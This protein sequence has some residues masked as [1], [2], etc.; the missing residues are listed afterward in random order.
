MFGRAKSR[1]DSLTAADFLPHGTKPGLA[2]GVPAGFTFFPV[3]D[4]EIEG[5]D[6]FAAEDH[7]A[8]L[9]RG[10]V[11]PIAGVE[12]TGIDY[13]RPIST[14]VV[15]DAR[16]ARAT[17]AGQTVLSIANQDLALLHAA[18]ARSQTDRQPNERSH[19]IA[20]V[21]SRL[22]A[23]E[24]EKTVAD[25]IPSFDPLSNV[26]YTETIIGGK[27]TVKAFAGGASR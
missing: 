11:K 26:R 6:S 13:S 10:V 2:A 22:G 18:I 5:L 9:I 19:L 4:R 27:R 25:E 21:R 3:A 14:V 12:T 15:A 16:I 7:V 17:L 24:R 20:V 1:G 23:S 8:I